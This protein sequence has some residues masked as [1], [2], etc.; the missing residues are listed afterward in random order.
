MAGPAPVMK[1]APKDASSKLSLPQQYARVS[2]VC[3]DF[4]HFLMVCRALGFS[5]RTPWSQGC[6]G[7]QVYLSEVGGVLCISFRTDAAQYRGFV[8]CVR[9]ARCAASGSGIL[10]VVLQP[11]RTVLAA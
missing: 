11:A 3:C 7:H 2:F 8:L 5:E 10:D 6:S 4:C 9:L 1:V